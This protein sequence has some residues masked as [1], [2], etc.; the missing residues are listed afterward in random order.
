MRIRRDDLVEVI[1]G[2]DKGE[3]GRVLSVDREAGKVVVEQV[4]LVYKHVRRSQKNPQG[5]RLSVERPIYASNVM[6]VCQSCN[7]TTRLGVRY[8]KD[9][10][11][12]RFCKSCDA[13]AG[14]ISPPKERYAK[15]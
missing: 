7:N 5:G 12:E 13:S 14:V 15:K 10:S 11:K 2:A 8:T 9:G 6:Y 1:T 3:R 4:G